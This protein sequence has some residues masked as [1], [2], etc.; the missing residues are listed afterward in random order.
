[1]E[2]VFFLI[3]I[4]N[5]I[6]L[7][8]IGGLLVYVCGKCTPWVSIHRAVIRLYRGDKP[9]QHVYNVAYIIVLPDAELLYF[10]A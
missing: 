5:D 4:N 3:I 10:V 8:N 7:F 2:A 6:F 9:L 1:M